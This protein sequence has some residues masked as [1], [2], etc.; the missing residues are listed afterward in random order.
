MKVQGN[1]NRLCGPLMRSNCCN[2]HSTA[3]RVSCKKGY[4]SSA[5]QTQACSP[6]L[7]LLL[8][9]VAGFRGQS[10]EIQGWGDG[11]IVLESMWIH[12][13]HENRRAVFSGFS[14]LRPVFKKVCFQALRFQNPCGW[15]AK[16]MQYMHV[17]AKERF[18]VDGLWVYCFIVKYGINLLTTTWYISDKSID[19]SY[20]GCSQV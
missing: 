6:L 10:Q 16:M 18:C 15:L 17:F 8:W 3:R 20:Q 4:I 14:T 1:Q 19:K 2:S 11:V 7:L 5:A 12:C 13:P 9:D